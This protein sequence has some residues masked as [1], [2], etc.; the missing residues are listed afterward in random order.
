MVKMCR[1]AFNEN[2][3]RRER[4]FSY[5]YDNPND[6]VILKEIDKL[7]DKLQPTCFNCVNFF[8]EGCLGGYQAC[9][10]KIH[11]CLE[12]YPNPHY[13]CDGSKCDDYSRRVDN[14]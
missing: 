14:G 8:Y 9:M 4:T 10:C 11:G 12:H 5:N 13:D 2:A 1:D 3:Q 6:L 7:I